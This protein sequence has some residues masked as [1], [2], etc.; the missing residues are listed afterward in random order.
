MR[1]VFLKDGLRKSDSILFRRRLGEGLQGDG[2]VFRLYLLWLSDHRIDG[3]S[4][5]SNCRNSIRLRYRRIFHLPRKADLQDRSGDGLWA[6]T[7]RVILRIPSWAI[8]SRKRGSPTSP[9]TEETFISRRMP[10]A[11]KKPKNNRAS[12]KW[13]T[14]FAKSPI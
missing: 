8:S 2:L 6:M 14:S 12:L 11:G 13:G 9:I 1:A 10:E 7:P 3:I 4:L 5:S